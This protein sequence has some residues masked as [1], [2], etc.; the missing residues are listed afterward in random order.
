MF[1]ESFMMIWSY[2]INPV[3]IHHVTSWKYLL[4]LRH[5]QGNLEKQVEKRGG[6]QFVGSTFTWA[7]L[8]FYQIMEMILKDNEKVW[9][10]FVDW[11][12][13]K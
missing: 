10:L 3:S 4:I 6:G 1:G 9:T 11:L 2:P 8:H 7:E 5:H 12:I 13:L